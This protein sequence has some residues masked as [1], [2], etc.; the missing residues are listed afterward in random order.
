M[1]L[2]EYEDLV[3]DIKH[4]STLQAG[5]KFEFIYNCMDPIWEN[6]T[7]TVNINQK[8]KTY[9]EIFINSDD[10]SHPESWSYPCC[11]CCKVRK[12]A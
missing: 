11:R 8:H 1:T 6:K 2:Q 5:D 3:N 4:I 7:Y 10:E 12:I 9:G